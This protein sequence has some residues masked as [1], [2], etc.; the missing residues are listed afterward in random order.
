MIVDILLSTYNSGEYLEELL[1]SLVTQS[2][3]D[4]QLLVRDDGSIDN[5]LLILSNFRARNSSKI[6]IIDEPKQNLGPKRSFEKL[7]EYSSAEYIMFCDHDDYWLPDKILDSLT[8]IRELEKQYPNKPALVFSDL[9]VVDEYLQE[10]HSSFWKYLKISPDNIFNT[11]KLL[12]NN[13]APG[14]TI[15]INKKAKKLVLPFPE[16]ARMHDWWIVLKV[17][18]SGVIN[19]IKKPTILYRQHKKNEIGAETEAIKNTS[20][21]SHFTNISHTIKK[22]N[23]SFQMMKCLSNNYSLIKLFY[24]KVRISLSKFM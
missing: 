7:L 22:N 5:T 23:E 2:F 17:A 18:E 16:Q 4:W 3:T 6:T 20:P 10:I 24:Y 9:R 13:P 11:Y 8:L 14:C 12:I 15:I 19:Y 1:E 21:L